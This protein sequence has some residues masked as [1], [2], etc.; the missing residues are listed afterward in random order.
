[1]KK[2]VAVLLVLTLFIYT[3]AFGQSTD[4]TIHFGSDE[5][6]TPVRVHFFSDKNDIIL[7]SELFGEQQ[8]GIYGLNRLLQ[9]VIL[10]SENREMFNLKIDDIADRLK[11]FG[12]ISMSEEYGVFTGDL[13]ERA[14][15][16]TRYSLSIPDLIVL[17]D[18]LTQDVGYNVSG[19]GNE[20][21]ALLKE[22]M[23]NV[24]DKNRIN[25]EMAFYKENNTAVISLTNFGNTVLTATLTQEDENKG[26]ELVLGYSDNGKT[27]YEKH[28]LLH[29]G[30]NSI[31]IKSSLY[32]DDYDL[33]FR[34]VVRN[35]PF[36]QYEIFFR[37]DKN[38]ASDKEHFS[39]NIQVLPEN[40]KQFNFCADGMIGYS[41]TGLDL[42]ALLYIGDTNVPFGSL[43]LE[44]ADA[45]SGPQLSETEN[46]KCLYINSDTDRERLNEYMTRNAAGIF[47]EILRVM[48][49]NFY[50]IF[51]MP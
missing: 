47:A 28:S 10:A 6:E 49:D 43:H 17:T 39:Y 5:T 12:F 41:E 7:E 45:D 15:Y 30:T 14:S 35:A 37:Q 44:Y 25:I 9:S 40:R 26:T 18:L 19:K 2:A 42:S 24:L 1:M 33:G 38:A 22:T 51:I 4:G 31:R 11:K 29:E 23:L 46:N 27:Y 8:I 32:A 16:R 48:P 3:T 36:L 50:E 13:F 21:I 34:N 20:L